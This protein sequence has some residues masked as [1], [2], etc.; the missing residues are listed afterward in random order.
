M[1]YLNADLLYTFL[2]ITSVCMCFFNSFTGAV[3]KNA[4]IGP[5]AKSKN[6]KYN[7][8]QI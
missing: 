2:E 7:K 1:E 4:T 6:N 5:L 3:A 8:S